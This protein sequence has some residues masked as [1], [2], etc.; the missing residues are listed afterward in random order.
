MARN[1]LQ[2]GWT[3]NYEMFF[4]AI[5]ALLMLAAPARVRLTRALSGDAAVSLVVIGKVFGPFAH[6]VAS[7]YSSPYLLEFAAGR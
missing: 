1:V 4:Y 2:N 3:L 5:F 6:P 7:T